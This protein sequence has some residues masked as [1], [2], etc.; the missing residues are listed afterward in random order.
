M[1]L[2]TQ[3]ASPGRGP[4]GVTGTAHTRTCTCHRETRAPPR[5]ALGTVAAPQS[6]GQHRVW[7]R[8]LCM[9]AQ[10]RHSWTR[11]HLGGRVV[12]YSAV[13]WQ[14]HQQV[15]TRV[16]GGEGGQSHTRGPAL[17]TRCPLCSHPR[18]V[19]GPNRPPRERLEELSCCPHVRA[20]RHTHTP[21]QL[22]AHAH[23]PHAH[24]HTRA[25]PSLAHTPARGMLRARG[26]STEAY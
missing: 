13:P 18:A 3:Q 12:T 2:L 22:H 11:P 15:C 10:Q 19:A 26:G 20:P 9:G 5:G 6:S 1:T 21:T 25:W 14:C 4:P 16:C 17:H 24:A 7:G 23:T 8:D